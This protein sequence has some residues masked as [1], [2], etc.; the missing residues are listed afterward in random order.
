MLIFLTLAAVA[1]TALA[2][3]AVERPQVIAS[4]KCQRIFTRYKQEFRP[5]FFVVSED[6]ELCLFNYCRNA[7]RQNNQ[8]NRALLRCERMSE[9]KCFVYAAYGQII[10]PDLIDLQ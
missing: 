9:K 4:E 2:D 10:A 1:D 8:R 3:S 7:C 6:G 5:L